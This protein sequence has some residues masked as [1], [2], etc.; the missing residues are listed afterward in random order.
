[1]V[2]P[3]GTPDALPRDV[4]VPQV[5]RLLAEIGQ[6]IEAGNP[7]RRKAGLLDQAWMVLM[8]HSGLRT[9]EIRRLR[10]GQLNLAGRCLRVEGSKS[11]ADRIVYLSREGL[12]A[13][14][15]YLSIRGGSTDDDHV[16][17]RHHRP[18]PVGYCGRR[19]L[20]YGNRCGVRITPH[21]LRH[22]AATFLLNAGASILT[23]QRLLGHERVDTTLRY[24]WLYDST[25]AND[26]HSAMAKV[27][28]KQVGDYFLESGIIT[29]IPA[30]CLSG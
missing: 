5:K 12:E 10:L 24:T 29:Q 28:G 18:L 21:Q 13:L 16:F 9:G 30:K 17:T 6:E 14:D 15:G 1:L 19:L 8:L 26:Y 7:V 22:T 2:E 11:N 3:L 27:E 4:P 25:V 23:V 20:L